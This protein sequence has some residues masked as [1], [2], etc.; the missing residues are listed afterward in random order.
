MD[1]SEPSPVAARRRPR[2]QDSARDEA[3]RNPGRA[4]DQVRSR[5]TTLE[6]RRAEDIALAFE[7]LK[8]IRVQ[9][10]TDDVRSKGYSLSYVD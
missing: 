6:I 8:Q 1:L 3:R 2:G 5:L 9:R 7:A 4:A 10:D